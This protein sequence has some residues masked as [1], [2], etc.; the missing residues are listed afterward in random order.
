MQENDELKKLLKDILEPM[1]DDLVRFKQDASAIDQA[2]THTDHD[3]WE[4]VVFLFE[5]TVAES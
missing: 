2:Y 3:A 4:K 5:K 1:K